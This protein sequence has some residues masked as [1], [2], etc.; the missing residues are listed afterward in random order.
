VT[1]AEYAYSSKK[2][3]VPLKVEP[4]Y[5]PDG[6]LGALIG[7]KLYFDFRFVYLL[8]FVTVFESVS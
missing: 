4:K 6:W 5:K 2:T 7:N 8:L 3:I 1:E